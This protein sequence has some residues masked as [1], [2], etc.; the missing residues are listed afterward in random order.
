VLRTWLREKDSNLQSL[1]SKRSVLPSYTIPQ[2]GIGA[3]GLEP[4]S[5]ANL[6]LAVYKTAALPLCYAPKLVAVKGVEPSSDAYQAYA[7]PLSYT[8]MDVVV[9]VGFEPTMSRLKGE[10]LKPLSYRTRKWLWRKDSNLRMV[11]LTERCLTAWLRHKKN[12][13][14]NY[15]EGGKAQS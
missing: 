10:C 11:A 15:R 7:L 14:A 5:R 6:A 3:A 8:A 12:R 1:R 2:K 9:R 13:F 4:A